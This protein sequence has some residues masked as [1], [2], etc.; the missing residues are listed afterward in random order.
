MKFILYTILVGFGLAGILGGTFVSSYSNEIFL[1]MI[2]PLLLSIVSILWYETS[3]K[4]S[5]QQLTNT[6]IKTF[7]A[8]AVFFAL[9]FILIFTYYDFEQIP[10]IISFTSFFMIFYVIEALFLQK[11]IKSKN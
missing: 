5:P 1:G 4:K 2:A 9:Y 6:L 10:F 7:I 11:L 3:V 8:R